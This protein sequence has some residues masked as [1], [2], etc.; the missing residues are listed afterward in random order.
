M[1]RVTFELPDDVAAALN[2]AAGSI[3]DELRAAAAAQLFRDKRVSQE[4]AAKLSGLD[5]VEFMLYLGRSGIDCIQLTAKELD[6]E[7]DG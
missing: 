6:A 5:R 2:M 7:F 1:T 4:V 3:G